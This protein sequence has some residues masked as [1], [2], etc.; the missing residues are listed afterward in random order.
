MTTLRKLKNTER[1][2]SQVISKTVEAGRNITQLRKAQQAAAKMERRYLY[3]SLQHIFSYV[4]E[5]FK[6]LCAVLND[7][8][9]NIRY[10]ITFRIE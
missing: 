7:K 9:A 1:L 8:L 6:R 5:Y 4:I 10:I 3:Q 2:G